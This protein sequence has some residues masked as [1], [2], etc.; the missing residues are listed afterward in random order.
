MKTPTTN[1]KPHIQVILSVFF[2]LQL[3]DKAADIIYFRTISK[4]HENTETDNAFILKSNTCV[5]WPDTA[6]S[7]VPCSSVGKLRNMLIGYL[8]ESL[9]RR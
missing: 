3:N 8:A 5:A 1:T 6:C 9:M 7:S 4:Y 2:I